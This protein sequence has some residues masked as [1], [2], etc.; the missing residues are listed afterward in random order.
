LGYVDR[1]KLVLRDWRVEGGEKNPLVRAGL[2][3]SSVIGGAVLGAGLF[4]SHYR[5]ALF[6]VAILALAVAWSI[7]EC[8]WLAREQR[9]PGPDLGGRGWA[10]GRL[11]GLTALCARS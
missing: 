9:A 11:P 3:I 2:P 1:S 10:S 6:G 4:L 7:V 5:I 8:G